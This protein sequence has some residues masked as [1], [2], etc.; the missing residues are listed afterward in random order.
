MY[1]IVVQRVLEDDL[2]VKASMK[3]QIQGEIKLVFVLMAI[4]VAL[5]VIGALKAL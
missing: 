2:N 3:W 1:R 5:G 4:G